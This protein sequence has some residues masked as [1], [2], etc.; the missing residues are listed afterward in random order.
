MTETSI[1]KQI[2]EQ[3]AALKTATSKATKSKEAANKYLVDAGIITKKKQAKFGT[4]IK[5]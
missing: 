3:L 5:K 1:R 2:Q 4:K